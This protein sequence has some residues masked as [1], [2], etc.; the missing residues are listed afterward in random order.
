MQRAYLFIKV[1]EGKE[2]EIRDGI[3]KLPD[4]NIVTVDVVFGS[5]DVITYIEAESPEAI[6]SLVLNQIEKPFKDSIEETEILLVI[7]S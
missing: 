4:T 3:K 2:A 5:V 7:E 1:K 6:K